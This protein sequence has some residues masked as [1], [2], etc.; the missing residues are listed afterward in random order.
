MKRVV[1]LCVMGLLT[2]VAACSGGSS[3]PSTV[4]A[5]SGYSNSSLNGTYAYE[6]VAPYDKN[7]GPFYSQIGTITFDGNGNVSAGATK[8]YFA[9]STQTCSYTFTGT[10][11]VQTSGSGS[12]SLSFTPNASQPSGC[13]GGTAQLAFEVA[14]NGSTVQFVATDG[15]IYGGSATKQ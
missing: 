10:Y 6:L 14:A 15:N 8:S 9:T 11:S 1:S 12:A 4:Q 13:N 2:T 5:Q 3:A 7:G